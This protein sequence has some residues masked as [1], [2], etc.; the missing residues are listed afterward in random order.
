MIRSQILYA[1]FTYKDKKSS[2]EMP[3]LDKAYS[4]NIE[5]YL[6]RNYLFSLN[7]SL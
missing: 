5:A 2:E 7:Q 4:N 3:G 1:Y 6:Y